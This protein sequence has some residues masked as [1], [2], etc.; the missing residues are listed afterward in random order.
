MRGRRVW[1]LTVLAAVNVVLLATL[2]VGLELVFGSWLHPYV[3]P[4]SAI[5]GRTNTYS[6]NLYSPPSVVTYA[7]DTYGLRSVRGPLE[8]VKF[9]TVGGSTTDQRFITEGATWHDVASAL[10]GFQIANAGIDGMTSAGHVMAVQQWLHKIPKLRAFYYLHYIGINDAF[11]SRDLVR[12]DLPG[13]NSLLTQIRLRSVLFRG[14]V[15]GWE[16]VR[17]PK[18][19]GH[20][21]MALTRFELPS[22]GRDAMA[23][24][25]SDPPVVDRDEIFDYVETRYKPNLHRLID[26]HLSNGELTILASQ[27][28]HPTLIQRNEHEFLIS[29][30]RVFE[31]WALALIMMNTATEQV[32][33]ERRDACKFIDVAGKL[34]FEATDFYDF[35]HTRPSGARKL[36]EFIAQELMTMA[37]FGRG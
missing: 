4:R 23:W 7:R 22:V 26:L 6:Q 27:P 32:C 11:L 12:P 9:V 3:P 33:R 16:Q 35:V 8:N 5:V 34:E 20:G 15:R 10:T 25:K 19:V 17:N 30:P 2:V 36:G 31:R 1:G 18:P 21:P 14:A 29:A 13:N 24:T 28:A 37:I